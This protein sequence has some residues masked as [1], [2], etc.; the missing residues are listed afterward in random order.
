MVSG[1]PRPQSLRWYVACCLSDEGMSV[2][3]AEP[4]LREWIRAHQV[5]WELRSHF[6]F[7]GHQKVHAGFD[8]A[9]FA[10]HPQPL[11]DDPGCPECIR[12]HRALREVVAM[13]LPA[14]RS[15][16]GVSISPFVAVLAMRPESNWAP[17]V[18]LDV[19]V[20][21]PGGVEPSDADEAEC[22][23][24]M[25]DE[26]RRLGAQPKSWQGPR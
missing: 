22:V 26:L 25:E 8:L 13:A 6:E 1:T 17:E 3:D 21:Q 20:F 14:S 7:T 5:T 19:E 16:G 10:R 23:H 4:A 2:Q 15:S 9:L 18:E 12:I 11:R 24:A